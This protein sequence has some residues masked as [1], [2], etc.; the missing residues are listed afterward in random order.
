M[1]EYS[2]IVTF[3]CEANDERQAARIVTEY[4]ER[5][6]DDLPEDM[7]WVVGLTR[8]NPVKVGGGK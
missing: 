4:L 2:V 7:D 3:S 5:V 6:V 1:D 8:D